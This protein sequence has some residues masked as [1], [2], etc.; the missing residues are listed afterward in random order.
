M[1]I[2]FIYKNLKFDNHILLLL[3]PELATQSSDDSGIGEFHFSESSST[4]ES[5]SESVELRAELDSPAA[6]LLSPP[7]LHTEQVT[8][9][10]TAQDNEELNA[11][12]AQL[13]HQNTNIDQQCSKINE[14][15]DSLLTVSLT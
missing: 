12:T 10:M 4:S 11:K 15:I 8:L 1:K 5:D 9:G 7:F 3:R 2:Y 14:D 13:C 6:T